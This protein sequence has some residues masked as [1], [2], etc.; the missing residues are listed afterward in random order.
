[1]IVFGI[2]TDILERLG[3]E[4]K[5]SEVVT[6]KYSTEEKMRKVETWK[7]E[8]TFLF[9]NIASLSTGIDGLQKYCYNMSF[10]ELPQRPA[11]LEQA[12]GRIDRMGQTQTMNVYFLLS[13]DT[14]DTQIR[15]LLDGKIKVTDAVNKG[16]DVQVSRDD[17]MDIALIKKLKEWKEKK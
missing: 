10:L 1:M 6:G 3:K 15:E 8:K 4:F 9:A 16:I 5:N 7:K 12:T 14:I 11:E 13:S 2:T 17:S